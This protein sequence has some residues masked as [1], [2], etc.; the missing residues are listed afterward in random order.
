MS[1]RGGRCLPGLAAV[2]PLPSPGTAPLAL[3]T[4]EGPDRPRDTPSRG[5]GGPPLPRLWHSV[6]SEPLAS[7]CPRDSGISD[8]GSGQGSHTRQSLAAVQEDFQKTIAEFG[9]ALK[10]KFP[11]QRIGSLPVSAGGCAGS[12]RVSGR[13]E[14]VRMEPREGTRLCSTVHPL[15]IPQQ[16]QLEASPVLQDISQLQV[17]RDIVRQRQS[18]PDDEEGFVPKKLQRLGQRSHGAARRDLL[19]KSP[20]GTPELL[21]PQLLPWQSDAT[22]PQGMEKPVTTPVIKKV[23]GHLWQWMEPHS[24]L[25]GSPKGGLGPKVPGAGAGWRAAAALES[26]ACQTHG[27][28]RGLSPQRPGKRGQGRQLFRSP[29]VPDG[30]PGSVPKRGLPSDRDSPASARRQRRVA[31]SPEQKPSLQPGVWPEPCRSAQLEEIENLLANDDQE[32]IG[33]FSKPHVLPTVEGKDPGLKY[34]S[35]GTLE[36]VL[37]GHYSSFIESSIVVDCRYPYEYEGGHVKGAVNLPLQQDVEKFLL[38]RPLVPQDIGKRVIIIFHCEFS[39]ERGPRMCKFLRE[40]DRSCHEYP[41]LHYPELYVLKGGYR[42]F[43][44]Q[45][46]GHCEPRDYRPMEHPAFRE[47]LRKFRGQRRRGRR[48]LSIR[49]RDL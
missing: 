49:G 44:F 11:R 14:T 27:Q 28:Q 46:P 34:I 25:V 48:A 4:A 37:S 35:P 9:R 15:A 12:C 16:C 45:F 36:K 24:P 23:R 26:A 41:Q 32:L 19:A 1:L 3:D 47:E 18:E 8:A 42:E 38:E 2:S 29:W 21:F 22:V 13:A 30:V 33:D 6:S 31:G 43:F 20:C 7:D 5:H 10:G 39:V 40:K 17:C